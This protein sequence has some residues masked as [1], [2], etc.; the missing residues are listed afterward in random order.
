MP[1]CRAG[2]RTIW[3]NVRL[4]GARRTFIAHGARDEAQ[5]RNNCEE[6]RRPPIGE[7]YS[8]ELDLNVNTMDHV[9]SNFNVNKIRK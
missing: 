6:E 1:R 2:D 4:S 5:M 8:T 9:V 3:H 7:F